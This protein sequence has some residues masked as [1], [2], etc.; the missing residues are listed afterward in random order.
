VSLS[1]ALAAVLS[2]PLTATAAFPT[3]TL[4]AWFSTVQLL[5]V[6]LGHLLAVYVAHAISFDVFP[7][8]LSPIRSQYPFVGVMVL[9]TMISVWIITQPFV[10]PA[11]V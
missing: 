1:P 4:P 8:A 2:S 9:Y 6:V 3:L 5:F 11:L 7:G 10:E